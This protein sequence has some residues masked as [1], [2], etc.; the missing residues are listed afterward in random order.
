ML[1]HMRRYACLAH[2]FSPHPRVHIHK[3]TRNRMHAR[4]VS[5]HQHAV[6]PRVYLFH[7]ARII[8]LRAAVFC[9]YKA[10]DLCAIS[11]LCNALAEQ[12]LFS[13]LF[14]NIRFRPFKS[15]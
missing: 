7:H 9:E 12:F 3:H 5:A 15:S 6:D 1:V 11:V 14:I 8:F 13:A 10:L 2:I 4:T